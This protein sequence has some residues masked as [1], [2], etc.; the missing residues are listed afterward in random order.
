M[1]IILFSLVKNP[2]LPEQLPKQ[3]ELDKLAEHLLMLILHKLLSS[4][5]QQYGN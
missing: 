4:K 3:T 1:A 2:V 5:Q